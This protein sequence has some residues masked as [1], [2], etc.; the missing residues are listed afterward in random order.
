MTVLL[1]AILALGFM[2]DGHTPGT[3]GGTYRYRR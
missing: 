2:P 3:G 1:D